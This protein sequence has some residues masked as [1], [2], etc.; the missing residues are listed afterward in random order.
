MGVWGGGHRWPALQ[1]HTSSQFCFK[2]IADAV[3]REEGPQL[4]LQAG[5]RQRGRRAR[6]AAQDRTTRARLGQRALLWGR[7]C[8]VRRRG[9]SER[10][11]PAA[12][13][14]AAGTHRP[15]ASPPLGKMLLLAV[16]NTV[17]CSWACPIRAALGVSRSL[18]QLIWQHH[19]RRDLTPWPFTY[20]FNF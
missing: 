13:V 8:P 4:W 5:R 14:Q 17:A 7:K 2:E 9:L 10:T 18:T 19:G 12:Q 1:H 20:L 15:C 16:A 6:D 11:A 3:K